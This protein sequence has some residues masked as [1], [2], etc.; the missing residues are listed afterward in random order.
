MGY[1]LSSC[2]GGHIG[3]YIQDIIRVP[4]GDTRSLDNG[5]YTGYESDTVYTKRSAEGS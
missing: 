5:S 2:K 1:S 4:K 3:E